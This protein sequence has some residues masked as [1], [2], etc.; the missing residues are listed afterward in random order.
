MSRCDIV[1]VGGGF[2]GLMTAANAVK[3]ARKRLTIVWADAGGRFARG[4]A[5]STKESSHLLNVVAG[6]MSAW[7]DAAGDFL[8]WL[9]PRHPSF[10]AHSFVPRMIYGDYLAEIQST[11]APRANIRTVATAATGAHYT[12]DGYRV[13]FADGTYAESP[14]LVL[15]TGNPPSPDPK[16]PE[17]E[18]F[19]TDFWRWRLSGGKVA[20]TA[21]DEPVVV[22]T[23][24]G[25]T[26]IDA[27]ISLRNDGYAGRILAVSP[28]GKLPQVHAST[29]AGHDDYSSFL[30][31]LKARPAALSYFRV[32]R[33]YLGDKDEWRELIESV[34]EHT[35]ALWQSL[36]EHE[37]ARFARHL[38][39]AWN[40][41]RH[42]M[43]PDIAARLAQDKN[44][45]V[46]AGRVVAAAPDGTI[47]VRARG[48]DGAWNFRADMVINCTGA[49]FR[50]VT[51]D[52]PVLADLR[53]QG[54]IQ[55][56][57]LRLGISSP[58]TKGLFALGTPLTGERLETV[59]V[60]ELRGQAADVAEVIARII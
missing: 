44:L 9:A 54:L 34:R 15:A 29:P 58:R 11:M 47:S 6:R 48:D 57:P 35:P 32:F 33:K 42:R 4:T 24:T 59:A 50:T 18:R 53:K 28:H 36:G 31:D 41:H 26:A 23:G 38:L 43:A 14:C 13:E 5:Y 19:V 60:P 39:S 46:M 8:R 12:E 55:P 25:L 10:N 56:G 20:K 22:V 2:C 7:P 16:W 1:I 17:D 37:K 51:T 3:L 30:R 52:N 27:I 49:G 21:N 45:N 40:I